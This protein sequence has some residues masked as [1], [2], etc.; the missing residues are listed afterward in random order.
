M[1]STDA[2][3][4]LQVLDNVLSTTISLVT[5][6][7]SVLTEITAD[8]DYKG[9]PNTQSPPQ[10]PLEALSLAQ[11]SAT[12]IRAHSTKI[13]LLIINEPFTP[14]AIVKVLR[15]LSAGPLPGLASSAQLCD[16]ARYTQAVRRDLSWRSSQVLKHLKELLQL[17]PRDGK[18]LSAEK[19]N[20]AGSATVSKGSIATTGVLWSAC[21]EV[22]A[23]SK[24]G[25]AGYLVKRVEQFRDTLK[26]V[27]EELKEWGEEEDED[28]SED[29]EDG[30]SAMT[31]NLQSTHVSDAQAMLDDLM[32]AHQHIPRD[33]PD[34]IRE[35]LDSCLKRL[36][37]TTLLYQAV[38]KRRLK[39]LPKLPSDAESSAVVRLNEIL[40][41]LKRIPERFGN[42]ALSFYE[43]E[44]ADIDRLMDQ[45][46]FDAFAV[47]ELL[48][49]PLSGDKEKDEF[50]DW[51]VKF[52]AEIKK[53]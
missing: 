44:A 24:L 33:D 48:A 40:P 7:E 9:Q 15:E 37:L 25:I 2:N 22:I 3:N 32:N 30:V 12:L 4:P 52:Q 41:L 13:S 14:T 23:L 6:L 49:K 10:Q 26:D 18:V 1:A 31:A 45:C 35:R 47:S 11:D 38:I 28:D 29:D 19:K 50:S 34:K 20:A 42:L 8:K 43:L 17:I 21:D 36:R 51:A 5:Q 53:G 27:L 39:A 46:F 16:P